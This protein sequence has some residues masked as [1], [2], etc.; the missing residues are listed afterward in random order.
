MRRSL[1]HLMIEQPTSEK[2]SVA[3]CPV[4]NEGITKFPSLSRIFYFLNKYNIAVTQ[5]TSPAEQKAR[6]KIWNVEL[7]PHFFGFVFVHRYLVE[8]D[9]VVTSGSEDWVLK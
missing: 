1:L 5:Q 6:R 7:F 3:P 4:Y 2:G 9:E 8:W